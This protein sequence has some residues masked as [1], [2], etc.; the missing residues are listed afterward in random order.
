MV[1]PG[2]GLSVALPQATSVGLDHPSPAL[3]NLLVHS[4]HVT[5]DALAATV[6]D[7]A[8]RGYLHLEQVGPGEVLC[9]FPH[10]PP[11]DRPLLPHE[12]QALD[13]L[14]GRAVDGVVP[15]GAL[16]QG[17]TDEAD[18][19]WEQFALAV[20]RE[21]EAAGLDRIPGGW[22]P[23][24]LELIRAAVC[25]LLFFG[26]VV[27]AKVV[28]DPTVSTVCGA[29]FVGAGLW[30]GAFLRDGERRASLTREGIALGSQWITERERVLDLLPD[31][32]GPAAVTVRGRTLAYA[33]AVGTAPSVTRGLPRGPDSTRDAW[34]RRGGMWR[35][36]TL[37]YPLRMPRGWGRPPL[38][39]ILP[40][41]LGVIAAGAVLWV[42]RADAEPLLAGAA[43][44]LLVIAGSELLAG[45]Y[46][47]LTA[48]RDIEGP[49][50]ARW[51]FDGARWNPWR[52]IVPRRWYV[53]ID[54]GTSTSLRGLRVSEDAFHKAHRGDLARA[55]V[56]RAQ[57]FVHDIEIRHPGKAPRS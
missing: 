25:L 52:D 10:R 28:Q 40:A 30:A 16:G 38:T 17:V 56:G 21:G 27:V 51:L 13:L 24:L 19:W 18:R 20:G 37:R 14:A 44:V 9:R 31:A 53:V 6:V 2:R 4:G 50:V 49:V 35:R 32:L 54:D 57:G 1:A 48:P 42:T 12:R 46:D 7:L 8:A 3:V 26:C 43:L 39:T 5:G 33:C 55:R 45:M 22:G 47:V 29:V 36:V 15:A 23:S 11:A 41:L 34:V